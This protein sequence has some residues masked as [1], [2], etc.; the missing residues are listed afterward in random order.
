[1]V[2]RRAFTASRW[3]LA[4]DRPY[5]A[6]IEVIKLRENYKPLVAGKIAFWNIAAKN[7][8]SPSTIDKAMHFARTF[9]RVGELDKATRILETTAG[10]GY[11]APFFESLLPQDGTLT[12]TDASSGYQEQWDQLK[13]QLTKTTF[14]IA[15]GHELKYDSGSFDRYLTCSGISQF[16]RPDIAI[17]EA[18]RVLK[19]GGI[20]V[21]NMPIDC[22]Y[23]VIAYKPIVEVGVAP[24][25]M[26]EMFLSNDNAKFLTTLM[27]EA[28]FVDC[29]TFEDDYTLA[30]DLDYLLDY[31]QKVVR[32]LIPE[33]L[34]DVRN[35]WDE[36]AMEMLRHYRYERKQFLS[37]KSI[38]VRAVKPN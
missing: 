9:S 25:L 2:L 26:L 5:T 20:F 6:A 23:E 1:M 21:G 27:E 34:V 14:E 31:Y 37:Y 4:Q 30:G 29:L 10:S 32:C 22:N 33:K 13:P 3:T 24:A 18:F 36:V 38:G 15:D 19:P 12:I 8:E 16:I 28:G 7:F 11:A 17:K 35:K